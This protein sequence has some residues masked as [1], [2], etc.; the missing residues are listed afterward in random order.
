MTK[1]YESYN[2]LFS[3]SKFLYLSRCGWHIGY[4]IANG[5]KPVPDWWMLSLE[6]QN[7]PSKDLQI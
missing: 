7:T 6:L 3:S 1:F 4:A 2:H 5:L